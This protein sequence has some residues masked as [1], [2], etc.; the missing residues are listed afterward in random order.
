M[1][2]KI[3]NKEC[4]TDKNYSLLP[5][6]FERLNNDDTLIVNMVGEYSFV[7]YSELQDLVAGKLPTDTALYNELKRKSFLSGSEDS[8]ALRSLS[9]KYRQRKSFLGGGP[10][11]HIFVVTLRCGNS[12]EYCQASRKSIISSQYDMSQESARHAV[13]RVF[14]SPNKYIT[15]EFQGGEPLLAF[16]VIKSVVDYTHEK[17]HSHGKS[18][19]FVIATSLQC[20]TDEMLDF[21]KINKIQISTSLDG[22]EW[23][24][25]K[26]RPSTCGNSYQSTLAGI[27]KVRD[28]I[29]DDAI[30]AM[31]TITKDSLPFHEEI[32]DEYVK[33]GFHSIFLR[34]LNM[35]G[36]AVKKESK[37]SYTSIEYFEFYKKSRKYISDINNSGYYLDEVTAS[38]ALNNMLTGRAVGY[39]DL[40][41]PCGDGTGVLVY[42]YNGYVYPSDEARM[43][44]DMGDNK[45]C[46]GS[47]DTPYVELISSDVM[48]G[49]LLSGVAESLPACAYCAY[50]PYCGSNPIQNYSRTGDMCGHRAKNDF[51]NKQKPLYRHL[52]S[53]LEENKGVFTS[54]TTKG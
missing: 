22:P 42:H 40:R 15:I 21:I 16:D 43:L 52:F 5:F 24:H 4:F 54:W 8:Y 35:Y 32:V 11:L 13:D 14:E 2:N 20:T 44:Y 36:F 25:N 50:L 17:N 3:R 38:L 45:F 49:I 12:C 1:N 53:L 18:I 7:K 31:T 19:V 47:V 27:R 23:L 29:D 37:V 28:A 6:N 51:C 39:V 34:P 48:A 10:G 9:A 30:A 41:S 33:H 26:N 46:L